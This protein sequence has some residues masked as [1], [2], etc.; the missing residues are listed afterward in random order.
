MDV[1]AG[2]DWWK[3]E[4]V[5]SFVEDGVIFSRRLGARVQEGRGGN[6]KS[7]ALLC[8][9]VWSQFWTSW[10]VVNSCAGAVFDGEVVFC[11]GM[12]RTCCCGAGPYTAA[13]QSG[14]RTVF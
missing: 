12:S 6:G 13:G 4:G 5:A 10:K 7:V 3:D 11:R 14:T 1:R 8:A 2:S 9:A